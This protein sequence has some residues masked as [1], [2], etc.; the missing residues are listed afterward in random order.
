M[1]GPIRSLLMASLLAALL[2]AGC[3]GDDDDGG[4]GGYS[5]AD[6]WPIEPSFANPQPASVTRLEP[7]ASLK[8]RQGQEWPTAGGNYVLGDY[9][10]GSAL[11]SGFFIADVR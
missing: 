9:V 2:L 8:D 11:G 6:P 4:G 10:F 7:V 5:Q 1:T 3:G